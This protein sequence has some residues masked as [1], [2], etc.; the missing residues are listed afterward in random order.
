M[1]NDKLR[2]LIQDS[3]MLARDVQPLIEKQSACRLKATEAADALVKYDIISIEKR[4][5]VEAELQD[6]TYA[7]E[8]LMKLASEVT[9]TSL[10]ETSEDT[11]KTLGASPGDN[12]V[13]WIIS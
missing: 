8:M 3:T 1:N 2:Q 10:G 12:L 9:A 4:A 11:G 7:Y 5:A 13:N 6:P